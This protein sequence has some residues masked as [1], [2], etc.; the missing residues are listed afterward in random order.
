MTPRLAF[1][2]LAALSVTGA[3][4][5]LRKCV[6][7]DGKVTYSDAVC[8]VEKKETNL[9]SGTMNVMDTSGLR[10][11]ASQ[12]SVVPRSSIQTTGSS[13]AKSSPQGTSSTTGGYWKCE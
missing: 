1:L 11:Y 5:Q 2:C 10:Q 8:A 4:A 13:T 6:G 9:R 7:A 12:S 3:Q